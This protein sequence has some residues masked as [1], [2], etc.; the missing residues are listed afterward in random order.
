MPYYAQD[1]ATV[2][3][4]FYKQCPVVSKDEALTKARL[5]LV[6]ATQITLGKVLHLVGMAA[7]EKIVKP[8]PLRHCEERSDEAIS[9]RDFSLT[10]ST[11]SQSQGLPRTFQVLAM[12]KR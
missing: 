4:S 11:D 1:L 2:F 3:H 12:A 10:P 7:P 5:K 6:K 9:Q 8:T